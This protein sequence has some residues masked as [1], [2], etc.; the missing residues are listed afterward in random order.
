VVSPAAAAA[1]AAAAPEAVG[2]VM[3]ARDFLEKIRNDD[4]VAAIQSAEK[5]TSGE[6]RVFISRQEFDDPVAAATKEFVRLEMNKTKHQNGVL[7]YVAPRVRKF[8]VIGDKGVHEKCGEKFWQ[9][10]AAEM[11]R[12]F[13]DGHFTSGL[14]HGVKKAGDLLAEHFPCGP[15]DKNELPDKIEGD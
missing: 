7:I 9:D 14:I 12:H 5:K 1:L 13:R 6:I 10:L 3:R 4:I 15:D 8:A 2:N 11:S